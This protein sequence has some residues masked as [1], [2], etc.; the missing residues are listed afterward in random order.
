MILSEEIK[1]P[2][3]KTKE[4]V[5]LVTFASHSIMSSCSPGLK[6]LHYNET[7]LVGF[8]PHDTN[9][10]VPKKISVNDIEKPPWAIP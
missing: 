6:K 2:S 9:A 4:R 1:L 3:I 8:L 10:K 7:V 5:A